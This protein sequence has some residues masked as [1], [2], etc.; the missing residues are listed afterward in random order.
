M[1]SDSHENVHRG[2]GMSGKAEG[3]SCGV[4]EMMTRSIQRWFGHVKRMGDSEM[5]RRV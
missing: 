5:T 3:M 4:V 1:K 2:F